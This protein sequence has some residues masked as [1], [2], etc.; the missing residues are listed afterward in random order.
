VAEKIVTDGIRCEAKAAVKTSKSRTVAGVADEL[1][2]L[3]KVTSGAS[4]YDQLTNELNNL[5]ECRD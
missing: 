3:Y 1:R 4:N 2:T 5:P